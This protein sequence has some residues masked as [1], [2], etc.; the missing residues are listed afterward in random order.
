M[1]VCSANFNEM[2]LRHYTHVCHDEAE[3]YEDLDRFSVIVRNIKRYRTK[4]D[5]RSGIIMNNIRILFNCLGEPAINLLFFK[6]GPYRAELITFLDHMR[7]LPAIVRL[8]GIE[9]DTEETDRN[10]ELETLLRNENA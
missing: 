8:N 1:N 4:N 10:I 7:L 2:F 3:L 9:I 6:A 5:L